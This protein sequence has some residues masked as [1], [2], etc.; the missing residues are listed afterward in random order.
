M[1]TI[2]ALQDVRIY[3][4]VVNY[5]EEERSGQIHRRPVNTKSFIFMRK[6]EVLA[7]VTLFYGIDPEFLPG[8]DAFVPGLDVKV[9]PYHPVKSS[10]AF[11]ALVDVE[12]S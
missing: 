11:Q 1:L 9:V 10:P 12:R 7:N 3:A 4:S 8:E 6:G 5:Q 2:T